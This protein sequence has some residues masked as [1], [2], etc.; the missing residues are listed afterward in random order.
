MSAARLLADAQVDVIGWSGTSAGWMGFETD[1]LLCRRI[2]VELGIPATTSTLALNRALTLLNAKKFGL[3]TPYLDNVQARILEVY[4]AAGYEVVAESHL[5][6]SENLR[7]AEI[8]RHTL[9]DQVASV[10]AE[11][12][13]EIKAIS[14]FCTNLHAAQLVAGW[15][16]QY[17]LPVL[18]SVATVVWDML[19]LV[20]FERNSIKGWGRLFEL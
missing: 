12:K 17:G 7:I 16:D 18:D 3:V 8:D 1:E 5:R 13:G 6:V 14:T 20:K 15:E 11:G 4:A 2:F 9:N 19:R 10:V